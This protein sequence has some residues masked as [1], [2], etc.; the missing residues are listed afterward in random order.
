MPMMPGHNSDEGIIFASPFVHSSTG[1]K[2]YLTELFPALHA[3]DLKTLAEEL[4][5]ADFSGRYGYTDEL[6]RVSQTF[7][8]AFIVCSAYGLNLGAQRN[9]ESFAYQF[10]EPPGYHADDLA[11]TYFDR[12]ESQQHV[13]ATLANIFQTYMTNFAAKGDPYVKCSDCAPRL[14]LFP[15]AHSLTLQN[16]NSTR[17]GPLQKDSMYEKRC[18]WWLKGLFEG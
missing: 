13:N 9:G 5:P 7:G 16:L 2:D 8:D 6:G 10:S 4:Y 11:Y 12:P 15:P 17:L 14:P 1:Y 18:E 3:E